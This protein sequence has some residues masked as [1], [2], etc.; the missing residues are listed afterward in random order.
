MG[1]KYVTNMVEMEIR[2]RNK[3]R[4]EKDCGNRA[5]LETELFSMS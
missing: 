3:V 4:I 2:W 5:G 1:D